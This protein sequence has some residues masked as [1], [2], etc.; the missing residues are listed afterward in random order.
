MRTLAATP[1][2][3]ITVAA[4][5]FALASCGDT[6]T[7]GT[8]RCGG[9]KTFSIS[10]KVSSEDWPSRTLHFEPTEHKG[11]S[12]AIHT[13]SVSTVLS[14]TGTKPFKVTANW[15]DIEAREVASRSS[16]ALP[17]QPFKDYRIVVIPSPD[18]VA[19]IN[20]RFTLDRAVTTDSTWKL[21]AAWSDGP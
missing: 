15:A 10:A 2:I 17:L 8:I 14:N 4:S 9:S 18:E 12:E 19:S 16:L 1:G 21:V 5:V 11:Y 7:M 3:R 6:S 20:F 13:A